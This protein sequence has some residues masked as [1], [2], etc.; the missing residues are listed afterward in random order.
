M[1]A[2]ARRIKQFAEY[3]C[4]SL[5]TT[6]T[7]K[8]EDKCRR[9][10]VSSNTSTAPPA[11]PIVVSFVRPADRGKSTAAAAVE[12]LLQ[13]GICS[14][15][16]PTTTAEGREESQHS[17]RNLDQLYDTVREIAVSG[18][19]VGGERK[20]S[21]SNTISFPNNSCASDQD[22]LSR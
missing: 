18:S 5:G 8:D 9:Y 16:S 1:V 15:N 11:D 7:S 10:T 6:T 12:R 22:M 17:R 4:H 14:G 3:R 19:G 20:M 13:P 2:R 21:R